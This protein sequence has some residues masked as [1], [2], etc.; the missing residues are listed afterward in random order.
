M[1]LAHSS[2][3][4][5]DA[6]PARQ[7]PPARELVVVAASAGGINAIRRMLSTLP[8]SFPATI[9]V[10][11]HR[12]VSSPGALGALLRRVSPLPVR[13]AREGHALRP[14]TVYLAPPDRRLSIGADETVAPGEGRRVTFVP[15]SAEPLF[16]AAARAFGPRVV[17]VVLT[18]SGTDGADGVR[19]VK[20]AGG[21][22][23]AQDRTTSE[24]FAM[25]RA[26]I[27]TGAVDH[28]LPLDLIGPMLVAL[29]RT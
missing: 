22:V 23:I 6:D 2:P 12:G 15:S 14:G 5:G 28:V 27:A 25:P 26:A 9:V 4:L 16:A 8:A 1:T 13:D 29:T 24:H 21:V 3:A 17:A 10:A 19:A 11:Q 18:G 7:A 20:D